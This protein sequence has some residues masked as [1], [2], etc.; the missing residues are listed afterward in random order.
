LRCETLVVVM[1]CTIKGWWV[2]E[3]MATVNCPDCIMEKW[4]KLGIGPN[5]MGRW[6]M[7]RGLLYV[8]CVEWEGCKNGKY[9]SKTPGFVSQSKMRGTVTYLDIISDDH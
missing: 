2:A 6:I 9:F 4:V 5:L 3:K 1:G 8:L 7:G